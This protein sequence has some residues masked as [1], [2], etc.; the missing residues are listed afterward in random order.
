MRR[1]PEFYTI[2]II[3]SRNEQEILC[4]K[5]ESRS[6]K[7]SCIKV[8]CQI[9]FLTYKSGTK[10]R[11]STDPIIRLGWR[12][13]KGISHGGT[14]CAQCGSVPV[15]VGVPLPVPVPCPSARI[16]ICTT[17]KRPSFY[18]ERVPHIVARTLQGARFARTRYARLPPMVRK[19]ELPRDVRLNF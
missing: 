11:Q 7:N 8:I 13:Y 15:P 5:T 17:L 9:L 12:F 1:Y 16:F 2:D 19:R 10:E 18:P 14:P 6:T 3:K 4:P